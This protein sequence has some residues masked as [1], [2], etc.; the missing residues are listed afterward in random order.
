MTQRD[1][2]CP[3]SCG[4]KS[5]PGTRHRYSLP[6]LLW[7]PR[8]T[9]PPVCAFISTQFHHLCMFVY[10]PP[11]SWYGAV[12]I[13][14]GCPS[15]AT[16]I[17]GAS[18]VKCERL[19][20]GWVQGK[21]KNRGKTL[22]DKIRNM[23]LLSALFPEVELLNPLNF[24]WKFIYFFFCLRRQL[25][26][27][28]WVGA[29]CKKHQARIRSLDLSALPPLLPGE[30]WG[31]D[32]INSWSNLYDETSINP[33]SVGYRELPG[34]WEHPHSRRRRMHPKSMG[35]EALLFGNLPHIFLWTA[36]SSRPSVLLVINQ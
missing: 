10:P 1:P 28:S 24:L 30:K 29:C 19:K 21:E 25:L 14:Q 17:R 26:V 22:G 32:W 31:R 13:S 11:P 5:Q 6:I 20:T 34:W 23:Y 35:T 7:F 3:L 8:F 36:S 12:L 33:Y 15:P 9:C 16:A 27:G 2:L 4:T 18:S